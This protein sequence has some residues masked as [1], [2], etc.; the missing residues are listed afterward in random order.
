MNLDTFL[1]FQS[2]WQIHILCR[3]GSQHLCLRP[4]FALTWNKTSQNLNRLKFLI[5]WL[6]IGGRQSWLGLSCTMLH[7]GNNNFLKQELS[8]ETLFEYMR[9]LLIED[10][11]HINIYINKTLRESWT[12]DVI[13]LRFAFSIG[14]AR[15]S[16]IALKSR[17]RYRSSTHW[18]HMKAD[19]FLCELCMGILR[20][21]QV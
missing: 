8:Q 19:M 3:R 15:N 6:V 1:Y 10:S 9:G 7:Y 5:E 17:I 20:N 11:H 2:R 14:L 18:W 16:S 4:L 21:Q 12:I 13:G